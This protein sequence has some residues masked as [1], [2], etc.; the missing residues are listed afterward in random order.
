[1]SRAANRSKILTAALIALLSQAAQAK[2][3]P[4]LTGDM[5]NDECKEAYQLATAFF[6]SYAESPYA[7]IKRPENLSSKLSLYTTKTDISGG[8]ALTND[9]AVFARMKVDDN[10]PNLYGENPEILYWQI[11]SQSGKRLVITERFFGDHGDLY[12][13]YV[14]DETV[15]SENF[16]KGV[17]TGAPDAVFKPMLAE[18]LNPA[19][20]L[21]NTRGKTW[22]IDKGDETLPSWSV[23]TNGE[24]GWKARCAISF[25]PHATRGA[26]P[27]PHAVRKFASLLDEALGPASLRPWAF[28]EMPYNTRDMVDAG[29]QQWAR[30][31]HKYTALYRSIQQQY[32]K[33]EHAL[34]GYY[35]TGF[36][37]SPD[38]ARKMATYVTDTMFRA[39]FVFPGGQPVWERDNTVS[40]NPWPRH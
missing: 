22:M 21:T 39:Y 20:I 37:L 23:Y 18:E 11:E 34:V 10:A 19:Q 9:P 16:L 6:Y 17:E 36:N 12:S 35:R 15:T 3:W 2:D 32:P 7:P 14:L 5:N 1:M 31:S 40:L 33:A 25:M 8:D 30:G 24:D 28:N 29:L 4:R 26:S 38:D 27:M 13:V